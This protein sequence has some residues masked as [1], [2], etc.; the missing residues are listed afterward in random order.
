MVRHFYYIL[1]FGL[2]DL[3]ENPDSLCEAKRAVGFLSFAKGM[4]E[5]LR[6]QR[7]ALVRRKRLRRVGHLTAYSFVHEHDCHG[8]IIM[9]INECVAYSLVFDKIHAVLSYRHGSL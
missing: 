8:R 1:I 5:R 4:P 6:T 3:D 2:S 7:Q 9:Q